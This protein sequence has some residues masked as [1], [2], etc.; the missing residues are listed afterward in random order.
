MPI[1]TTDSVWQDADLEQRVRGEVLEFLKEND[2]QAFHSFELAD[3]VF[4]TN[5]AEYHDQQ[6]VI[7]TVGEDEYYENKE[8][9]DEEHEI[10]YDES[11]KPYDHMY[12]LHLITFLDKLAQ[13][14]EIEFRHIPR[15]ETELPQGDV[16]R[17]AFYTYAE[18]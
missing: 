17:Q 18:N 1:S 12:R 11:L 8:Q 5:W 7:N 9:Y 3:E 6:A 14:G 13:N 10:D 4:D 16:E 2:G 15:D